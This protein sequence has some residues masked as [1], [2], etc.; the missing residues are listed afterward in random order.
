MK[1]L[2]LTSEI[3]FGGNTRLRIYGTLSCGSGKRMKKQNRVFFKDEK[4]ARQHKFRPCGYCL[5]EKYK[6]WI[7]KEAG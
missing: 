5:K 6:R 3:L 2:I 1:N 4:E 7:T